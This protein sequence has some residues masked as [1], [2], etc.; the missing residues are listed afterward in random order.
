[1][2]WRIRD[3]VDKA[4]EVKYE[5]TAGGIHRLLHAIVADEDMGISRGEVALIKIKPIEIPRNHVSYMC[6]YARNPLGNAIALVD[7]VPKL[8]DKP[9]QVKVAAFQAWKDG[10]IRKGDVIGVVDFVLA[11]FKKA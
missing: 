10:T 5:G 6:A 9:R 11:E 2:K 8:I 4:F 3:L 7:E 1:M